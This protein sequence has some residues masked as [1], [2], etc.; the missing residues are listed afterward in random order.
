MWKA[1]ACCHLQC[2][3]PMLPSECCLSCITLWGCI[4]LA[5]CLKQLS[6][7]QRAP[8]CMLPCCHWMEKVTP[9]Q[10]TP[11]IT[12]CTFEF[13]TFL[14]LFFI[15]RCLV[16]LQTQIHPRCSSLPLRLPIAYFCISHDSLLPPVIQH[17]VLLPDVSS[18]FSLHNKSHCNFNLNLN[19]TQLPTDLQCTVMQFK[20]HTIMFSRVGMEFRANVF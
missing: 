6:K 3:L 2:M 19:T 5:C 8:R 16:V 10:H 17:A 9:L 12:Q 13:A 1:G 7:T 18:V 20:C 4:F 11:C 14:Y 15:R